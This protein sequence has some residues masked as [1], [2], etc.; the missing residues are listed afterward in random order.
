MFTNNKKP[1][2][3]KNSNVITVIVMPATY[4]PNHEIK[5]QREKQAI[6]AAMCCAPKNSVANAVGRINIM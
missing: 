1:R 5:T 6:T 2:T 3:T 4:S